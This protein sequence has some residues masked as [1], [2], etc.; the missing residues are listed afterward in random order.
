VTATAAPAWRN[1]AGNETARPRRVA[2]PRSAAEVAQEIRRAAADG[3]TVRMTGTGHSFT[4]AAATDG[5][6]LLP[7]GLTGIR[8]VDAAAGLVTV[9]AGCP[10]RV[11]NAELLARGLSL[12]NMGDIQVQ[13][14]AGA[15]QT[16]THGTGRDVG[17]MA[18]Q[19]AG[20][21]LVRADGTVVTCSADDPAGPGRDLF[22]AARV[23]LGALGVL[24]AVTFRVVPAFLLQAR[25]EPMRWSEVITRLD[26]LTEQ[27]EHFEFYWFPHTEGC[28][29]KRNNR[30]PGPPRPLSRMRYLLDDELL[31]NTVFGLT[32]RLGH[33]VPAV[34]RPVNRVAGKALGA[35]T[36]TDAA[37]RVFTSPRRVRFKEQEYAVP[38]EALAGVLGEVRDLFARRDWRISFPI[39]VRVTP[40]DE[41]WLSTAYGRD[42]AYIAIHVFHASPHAEYFGDVEAVMT[43]AGG[44]PHW[45]K[46][47]TRSADYLR[48]AYPKHGDFAALRD[49]LDPERRFGNAY[50]TQVLGP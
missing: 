4:P 18:A 45:G 32:C 48:Q 36:Y 2:T 28:L 49:E 46:M 20:L 42:S 10:L 47:H 22:D 24:T 14:V 40:G 50:L 23:G 3:L 7:G 21:E 1:W 8:S 34:I 44:R 19:V 27:N 35:R 25:E 12:A 39:E 41:P 9:E 29:V 15:I 13:T 31:S 26:E 30:V 43:A 37:Y 38:R 11:L 16:G 5:V 17:G 6:R 33:A